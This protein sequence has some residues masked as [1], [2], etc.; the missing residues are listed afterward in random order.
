[1]TFPHL[2]VCG[3]KCRHSR[4]WK[5]LCNVIVRASSE[6]NKSVC[7]LLCDLLSASSRWC[8]DTDSRRDFS[9]WRLP[10]NCRN[11]SSCWRS[12]HWSG[13]SS[14]IL[15]T[16]G[17]AFP[18]WNAAML[19]PLVKIK[20]SREYFY[21]ETNDW[22]Y[23]SELTACEIQEE[24]WEDYVCTKQWSPSTEAECL[25]SIQGYYPALH[26][27]SFYGNVAATHAY[28]TSGAFTS[29]FKMTCYKTDVF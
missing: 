13:A 2:V 11:P 25:R 24:C 5:E 26:S 3:A 17:F 21:T 29:R 22:L 6:G 8:C 15:N 14:R 23:S 9:A 12:F 18:E 19:Q 4:S 1:M 10:P 28:I 27:M 7:Q 20:K 16:T